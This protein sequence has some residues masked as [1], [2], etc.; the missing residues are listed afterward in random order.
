MCAAAER[1]GRLELTPSRPSR[2]GCA[3]LGVTFP[4]VDS[5]TTLH[6]LVGFAIPAGW[7]VLAVWA[8]YSFV[9]NKTPVGG[10]WALLGALQVVVA[11]QFLVGGALF[12]AGRRASGGDLAWLHY[13]YGAFFPAALLVWAHSLAKG[14]F[15]EV[16][17]VPFGIAALLCFGLTARALMTGLQGA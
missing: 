17:F 2:P 15:R 3:A 4:S 6:R 11:V 13:V 16:P 8:L 5:V 9:R 1:S 14:R 10:F 7:L 12:L